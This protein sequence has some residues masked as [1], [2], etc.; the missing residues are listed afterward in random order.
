MTRYIPTLKVKN[1]GNL[2]SLWDDSVEE[3]RV[4]EEGL[5]DNYNILS[6]M[7]FSHEGVT[8]TLWSIIGY[9][10]VVTVILVVTLVF[11]CNPMFARSFICCGCCRK[12]K[13]VSIPVPSV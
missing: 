12:P 5:Q 7:T 8:Y 1:V 6:N 10:M 3:R 11:A 2:I 13:V 4:I 9:T